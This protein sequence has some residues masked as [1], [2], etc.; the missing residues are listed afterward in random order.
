ML[1]AATL[2]NGASISILEALSAWREVWSFA[3][4]MMQKLSL[5]ILLSAATCSVAAR[6]YENA[7]TTMQAGVFSHVKSVSPHVPGVAASWI[8]LHNQAAKNTC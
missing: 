2:Q 7:G 3:I 5:I 6:T 8:C 1:I 4:S